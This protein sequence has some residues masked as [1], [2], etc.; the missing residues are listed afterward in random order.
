MRA[1]KILL[2]TSD[3]FPPFRPAAKAIFG[4]EFSRRGHKVDWIMQADTPDVGSGK[5]PFQRGTVYLAATT[6]SSSRFGRIKKYVL[7]FRNDLRSIGL[8]R[9]G[10]YDVIQV[11]DRYITAILALWAAK[12]A[13]AV[14][15]YWLAY[16]HAEA[17]TYTA[18]QKIARYP[19]YYWL[20]GWC[21]GHLLYRHILPK[22]DHIFVQSEQMRLDIAQHAIPLAK[23]TPVPSSLNLEDVPFELGLIPLTQVREVLYVGTLLRER[24][25]EFLIQAF[26]FVQAEVPDSK[27]ILVGKGENPQDVERLQNEISKLGLEGT[28]DMVGFVQPE[29]V[30]DYVCRASV[31]VSPY[32]PTFILNSTSPT[33][34]IEYMAMAKPVVANDHPEQSKIISQSGAGKCTPWDAE[35]FGMAVVAMLKDLDAARKMGSRGR[36]WVENNR[37]NS[38]MADRVLETYRSLLGPRLSQEES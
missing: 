26:A 3:K 18:K 14:F 13:G 35:Q 36:T 5:V 30:W 34:L 15:C 4:D 29:Q 20:R 33:K 16:P 25:L 2:L 24:H 38:L 8:I 21:Q 37:K 7:D 27:L 10:C 17:S 6:A 22:A 11:K 19:W 12:R 28:V 31:C 23:M 9:D 32:Y 1:L